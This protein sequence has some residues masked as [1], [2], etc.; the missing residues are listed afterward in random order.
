M[1]IKME[2]IDNDQVVQAKTDLAGNGNDEP[3]RKFLRQIKE[4]MVPGQ[5]AYLAIEGFDAEPVTFEIT[6]LE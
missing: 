6:Q 2:L 3:F 5:T 4:E 1:G